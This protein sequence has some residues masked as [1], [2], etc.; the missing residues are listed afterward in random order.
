MTSPSDFQDFDVVLVTGPQRSG[1]RIV[2]KAIAKDSG[3]TYCDETVFNVYDEEKFFGLAYAGGRLVIQCP[4]M[5]H[6]VHEIRE[7]ALRDDMAVVMVLRDVG[8]IRAS[9]KR[10]DWPEGARKKE[11]AHY[12]ELWV[13][14]G[15]IAD[16]KYQFW[17][18]TQK[19][20]IK[21]AF[22]FRYAN[23]ASHPLWV[24]SSERKSFAWNQTEIQEDE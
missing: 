11:E 9:E 7:I 15:H 18:E 8:E 20:R 12:N 19:A 4:S 23:L 21:N 24:R 16:R 13:E 1:T 10:I 22:E 6:L 17:W 2:A 5:S 3:L 14:P